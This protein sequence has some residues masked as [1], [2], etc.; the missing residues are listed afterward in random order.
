MRNKGKRHSLSFK[1]E[2]KKSTTENTIF[3]TGHVIK[4]LKFMFFFLRFFNGLVNHFLLYI[5]E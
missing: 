4:T 5:L 3:S 2:G 1:A